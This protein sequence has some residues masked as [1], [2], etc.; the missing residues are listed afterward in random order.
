M[1]GEH[2]D[3]RDQFVRALWRHADGLRLKEFEHRARTGAIT[4][5]VKIAVHEGAVMNS[6]QALEIKMV[7]PRLG[8][9]LTAC[10]KSGS[11]PTAT[12]RGRYASAAGAILAVLAA[13]D[14]LVPMRNLLIEAGRLLESDKQFKSLDSILEFPGSCTAWAQMTPLE[15]GL[16]WVKRRSRTAWEG[17]C[18]FELT[19]LGREAAAA[20]VARVGTGADSKG[21]L[22]KFGDAGQQL[23]LVD[24]REGGGDAHGLGDVSRRLALA[25]VPHETRRLPSGWGDYCVTRSPGKPDELEALDEVFGVVERKT[26][27]DLADSLVD[28]RWTSQ[29]KAMLSTARRLGLERVVYVVEG[30]AKN[31]VHRAC[32]CGCRGVGRCG[33]PRVDE[34]E[35]ALAARA[36]ESLVEIHRTADSRATAAWLAE[37]LPA[38]ATQPHTPKKV[39]KAAPEE[40][41]QESPAKKTKK[42]GEISTKLGADWEAKDGDALLKHPLLALKTLCESLGENTSGTKKDLVARLMEK[43]MPS[44][45]ATRRKRGGYTPHDRSCAHAIMCA[46]ERAQRRAGDSK[47][48]GLTKDGVMAAAEAT[49]VSK[50]SLFA[51]AGPMG[52]DGWACAQDL[53]RKGEPPLVRKVNPG[54]KFALTTRNALDDDGSVVRCGRDVATALHFKAHQ[55]NWCACKDPPPPS[56]LTALPQLHDLALCDPRTAAAKPAAAKRRAAT[57]KKPAASRPLTA[58]FPPKPAPATPPTISKSRIPHEQSDDDDPFADDEPMVRCDTKIERRLVLDDDDDDPFVDDEPLTRPATTF[59][60]DLTLDSPEVA[61]RHPSTPRRPKGDCIDLTGPSP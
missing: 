9:V 31:H 34:I 50:V 29:Y 56:D 3:R 5:L 13:A 15:N 43:P 1:G 16:G 61:N 27:V 23:L 30:E 36:R 57:T 20:V 58:F 46:L 19:A 12:E 51:K 4:A 42:T 47:T 38:P 6:Y 17:K 53:Q 59:V 28:G 18:G 55:R 25:K 54:S 60:V 39:R 26:A 8:E 44:V 48:W 41:K 24:D 21:A 33:N 32:G 22:R 10:E 49:G 11:E 35:A 14:E 45:L 7:G 37:A 40:I 2:V 52:Y